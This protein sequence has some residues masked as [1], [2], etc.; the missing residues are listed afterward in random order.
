MNLALRKI[1]YDPISYIHPQRVSL[2]I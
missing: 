2:N 1:I